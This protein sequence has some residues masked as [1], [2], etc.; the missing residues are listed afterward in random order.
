MIIGI[1]TDLI[2]VRRV[3]EAIKKY[4]DRF[5]RRIFTETEIAYCS[6]KK[7]AALHYAGRFAAKEAAFK[8]LEHGWGGSLS[9]KEVEISNEGSGA[10]RLTFH[11]KALELA[12][13]KKV[14][15]AYVTISH[16]QE[17]ASAVVIL[18]S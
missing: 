15:N 7:T 3:Q 8:A 1:G 11:G 5:A 18:E 9:W 12:K 16:I 13:E 6:P 10:P 2:E 17:Y 4:G 14:K